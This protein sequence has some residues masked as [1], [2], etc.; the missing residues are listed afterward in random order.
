MREIWVVSN[1]ELLWIKLLWKFIYKS[2]C[3]HMHLFFLGMYLRKE[4]LNNR[5]GILTLETAKGLLQKSSFKR[6]FKKFYIPTSKVWKF[7]LLNH[8]I[9]FKFYPFEC[10][11]VLSCMSK[12]TNEIRNLFICFMVIC[13]CFFVN[14]L[15]NSIYQ[16][17]KLEY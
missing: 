2:F 14:C 8:F 11:E 10:W 3:E 1:F 9:S 13:T 12:M 15:F 16:I 7:Q 17:D 5:R 4:W 6:T